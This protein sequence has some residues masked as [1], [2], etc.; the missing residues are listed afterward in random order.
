MNPEQKKRLIQALE[1]RMKQF[2]AN[3]NSD[4]VGLEPKYQLHDGHHIRDTLT[5]L[6]VLK[7][8]D[9]AEDL[10]VNMPTE[11]DSP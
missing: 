2:E 7:N 5:T 10:L 3:F 1:I 8:Q 6:A 9:N 4:A 11:K